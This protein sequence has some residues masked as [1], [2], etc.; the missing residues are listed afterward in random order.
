LQKDGYYWNPYTH[1]F[2][3][4]A[5]EP[6]PT[7]K[8][9]YPPPGHSLDPLKKRLGEIT[10]A[11]LKGNQD[12]AEWID[13]GSEK[14]TVDF[15]N[16]LEQS[17][18]K[19]LLEAAKAM[20]NLL[21]IALKQQREKWDNTSSLNWNK[22]SSETKMAI[23]NMNVIKTKIEKH[24][25]SAEK[26]QHSIWQAIVSKMSL[27]SKITIN[28]LRKDIWDIVFTDMFS[29]ENLELVVAAMNAAK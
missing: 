13:T 6:T 14:P 24:D 2:D 11:P 1:R 9:V 15:L 25:S 20:L 5:D 8:R 26:G 29:G 18:S 3:I 7:Y 10:D 19:E 12:L 4:E 21:E 16:L 22:Y 23:D 27:S 28:T 17:G